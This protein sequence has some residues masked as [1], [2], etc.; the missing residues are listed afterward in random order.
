MAST[1]L[2]ERKRSRER[3]G[4][5]SEEGRGGGRR[6]E[7]ERSRRRGKERNE[8][9]EKEEGEERREERGRKKEEEGGRRSGEGVEDPSMLTVSS[10]SDV[11]RRRL[12]WERDNYPHSPVFL[13]R[14]CG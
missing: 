4:G 6:K 1:E 10:S 5:R 14:E 12:R 8:E 9:E 7:R 2:K 11:D 13:K 3:R